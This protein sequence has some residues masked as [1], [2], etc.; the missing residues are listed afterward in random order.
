MPL[1]SQKCLEPGTPP[2][3]P[4]VPQV[5][6]QKEPPDPAN[7]ER[8]TDNKGSCKWREK[9]KSTLLQ[10]AIIH[11]LQYPKIQCKLS[12]LVSK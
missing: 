8:E 2:P 6:S 7:R 11:L 4:V 5:L 10:H 9:P 1:K 3:Q 12:K